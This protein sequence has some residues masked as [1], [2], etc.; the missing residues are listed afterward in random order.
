MRNGRRFVVIDEDRDVVGS[1]MERLLIWSGPVLVL[2]ALVGLIMGGFI[3]PPSPMD[4]GQQIAQRFNSDRGSIRMGCLLMIVC[5]PLWSTFAGALTAWIRRMERGYR[6]FTY[7][8]VIIAGGASLVFLLIPMTWAVASFRPDGIDPDITRALND[9]TW[10]IFLYTWPPF[11][12]WMV[13][14]G[15]AV[16]TDRNNP[17]LFPRWVAFLN[18]WLAILMVPGGMI[19]FF[20]KGPFAFNGVFAF[21]V[22]MIAFFLWI[23]V[24]SSVMLHALKQRQARRAGPAIASVKSSVDLDSHANGVA[25]KTV[26][27]LSDE[28][29]SLRLKVEGLSPQTPN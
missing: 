16:L 25:P 15:I 9:W 19:A 29:A 11:A 17:P 20:K 23:V 27:T 6:G 13:L 8:S 22:V 14:I 21:W 7:S 26:E 1:P 18:F 4:S 28:L 5:F 24:M 12:L 10:Y 2:S 3:P